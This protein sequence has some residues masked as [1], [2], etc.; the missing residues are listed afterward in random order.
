MP[1]P[2]S[3]LSRQKTPILIATFLTAS[4]LFVGL[5]WRA[6]MARS[7]AAKKASSKE[8]NANANFSVA[9]GR[10]DFDRWWD[11]KFT[12]SMEMEE[13]SKL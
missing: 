5:K 11:L 4:S 9:T 10:S 6:V 2:Q 13:A 1:T 8:G 7:E 12:L 3:L